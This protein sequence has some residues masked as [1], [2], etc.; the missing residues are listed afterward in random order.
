[1]EISLLEK[2]TIIFITADHET[3]GF[4]FK[5]STFSTKM[6]TSTPVFVFSTQPF[7]EFLLNQPHL[8]RHILKFL[9]Q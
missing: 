8:H 1:M 6:H 7:E 3:G 4:D 5:S 2:D 9:K